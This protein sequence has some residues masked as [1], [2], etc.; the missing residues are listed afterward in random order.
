[1]DRLR[2][3]GITKK[4]NDFYESLFQYDIDGDG[5]I[6]YLEVSGKSFKPSK[7]KKTVKGNGKSKVLKGTKKNN[8]IIG[9]SISN[10]LKGKGGDDILK[11]GESKNTIHGGSGDDYLVG[12]NKKDILIGGKGSDVF[13]VS[14]G[15]D[16][17]ED[18]NLAEGDRVALKGNAQFD[19]VDY[20]APSQVSGT[21]ISVGSTQHLIIQGVGIDQFIDAI[22]SSIVSI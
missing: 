2:S 6:R 8:E 14:K 16:I 19:L 17:V 5:S 10:T 7:T 9:D 20:Q 11:G 3:V 4:N 21:M 15:R 1:M 18:F 22:D 12:G 13:T